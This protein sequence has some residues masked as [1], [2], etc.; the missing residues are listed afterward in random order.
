MPIHRSVDWNLTS[1]LTSALSLCS[2]PT[3]VIGKVLIV[4]INTPPPRPGWVLLGFLK[5]FESAHH[6]FLKTFKSSGLDDNWALA[7]LLPLL[8]LLFNLFMDSPFF[9][10]S[11]YRRT[12]GVWPVVFSFFIL[13][14]DDVN[15]QLYVDSSCSQLIW[16]QILGSFLVDNSSHRKKKK[17]IGKGGS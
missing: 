6:S 14:L 15:N 4:K 16:T 3:E 12:A 9:S 7:L 8:W 2:A 13:F 10:I 11:K 5:V 17:W 1:G